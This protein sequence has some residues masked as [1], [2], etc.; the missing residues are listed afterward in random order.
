MNRFSN[1][2]LTFQEMDQAACRRI[3]GGVAW[4]VPIIFGG[5][6]F[7]VL[8]HWDHFKEGLS[9]SPEQPEK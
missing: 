5:A 4:Y 7:Q 1:S 2:A 3:S 9:G 8:S 6:L